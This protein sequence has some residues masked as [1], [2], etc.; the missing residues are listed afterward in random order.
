MPQVKPILIRIDILVLLLEQYQEEDNK[1]RFYSESKQFDEVSKEYISKNYTEI[2]S[3]LLPFASKFSKINVSKY[4]FAL[5]ERDGLQR[6]YISLLH[7]ANKYFSYRE[8]KNF[9][10]CYKDYMGKGDCFVTAQ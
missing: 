10:V 9:F 3:L 5:I 8:P 2:I 7:E 6:F 1:D 4:N